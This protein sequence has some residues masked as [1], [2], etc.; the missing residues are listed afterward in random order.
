MMLCECVLRLA[1]HASGVAVIRLLELRS[2]TFADGAF[3]AL[4]LIR[5]LDTPE[6]SRAACR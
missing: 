6:P 3:A 1:R 5:L 4:R 2:F